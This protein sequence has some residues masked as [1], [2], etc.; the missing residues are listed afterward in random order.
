MRRLIAVLL[1]TAALS[2]LLIGCGS[3]GDKTTELN[4]GRYVGYSW[5]GEAKGTSFDDAGKYIE[6][7]L[8][9][10]EDGI[11]TDATMWF[12]VKKDGYWVTRQSGNAYVE[13]D[14]SVTPTTA[15][16]G[17]NYEAG[18]TMFRIYTADMMSF[19]A[20]AVAADGTVA[21][22]IV[23]PITRYQMEMKF[24][25]DFD[26]QTQMK[27]LTVDNGLMVP[28]IRTSGSGF[29]KPESFDEISG[30]SILHIHDEYSHVVNDQGKLA[31]INDNST[32][33]DFVGALGVSFDGNRPQEQDPS[34]G[35]FGL[36]GWKGNYDSISKNLVGKNATKVTS[37]VNWNVDKFA[38]G[39][40]DQRQFGMDVVSGATKTAQWSV[41]GISGATV[42]MSRESTSYQRA[43]VQAGILSEEEVVIGRF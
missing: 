39:V 17:S 9:L 11:I 16:P 20:T 37:L 5:A 14:F 29:M 13:V 6:T 22:A 34:Y 42:R 24:S 18:R 19:Y 32:V 21:V 31:H 36:G 8:E 33:R 3:D 10:D 27:E 23:D 35:Y 15:V 2:A 28:T 26:Y 25:P 12:W 38:K 30:R 40:N 4:A 43:L 1:T 7:I 41:D